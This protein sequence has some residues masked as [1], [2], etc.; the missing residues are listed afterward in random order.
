MR[1][2]ETS[3]FET[4]NIEFI[5]FWM[6]DPFV[7][8][9]L[10]MHNGGEFYFNLGDISEDILRDGRKSFE[11]GL[12]TSGIVTNVDTTVWGRV[13]TLQ[14]LVN[15]FDNN[16]ES[17]RFQDIGLDGLSDEDERLS[18]PSTSTNCAIWF[19][20]MFLKNITTTPLPIIFIITEVQ[21]SIASRL[22]FLN[23]TK[24]LTGPTAIH[25]T[26][27]MSPESY[28]TAASSIPDMEDINN[29]NTLER[30]RAVLPVPGQ[31]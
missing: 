27:E 28:P 8:D 11:Q 18:F 5:E 22:E 19:M 16:P 10:G 29:D 25:P 13:S 4:S 9:T 26:T 12:P 30:K 21:I 20:T 1:R 24:T 7:Y 23:G 14:S 15:A 17:R 3:D 31:H 6:M 2:I